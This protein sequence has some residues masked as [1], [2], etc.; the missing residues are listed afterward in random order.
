M[1]DV[2]I[3]LSNGQQVPLDKILEFI[4]FVWEIDNPGGKYRE[5]LA[6]QIFNMG[7]GQ[8]LLQTQFNRLMTDP[9]KYGFSVTRLI[10]KNNQIIKTY[11]ESN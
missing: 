2:I 9:K 10:D 1:K 6:P 5:E 8:E 11:V 4:K 7:F 3:K